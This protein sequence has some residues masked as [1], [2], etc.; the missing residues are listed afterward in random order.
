MH[1]GI[2]TLSVIPGK[3]AGGETYLAGLVRG[4]AAVD[5]ENRY[6]LFV[7]GKNRERFEMQ[8]ANFK[9]VP[10]P[11]SQRWRV[12][13]VLYEHFG[14]PRLTAR[15]GVDVLYCPG[16]AASNGAQCAVVLGAQSMHYCFVPEEVGRLRTSYFKRMVPRS[17]KRADMVIAVSEDIKRTLLSVVRIPESK[18]R[19]VYEGVEMGF[20]RP[21]GEAVEREL[22]RAGLR[23]GFVLFVSTL[24]PY[25]NADKLIRAMAH[26]KRAYGVE[27]EVV[28]AGRDPVALTGQLRALAKELG[29]GDTVR[30]LGGVEHERL[31]FF[32]GGADVFVYP[33]SIET[34]GL[35]I[36]EAMACGTP[37][38][39]SNC[40]SVPEIMGDAGMAVDPEDIAGMAEVIHG[41]L[42]DDHLR[43]DLRK[44]GLARVAEFTWER[45]A[46]ETL[47]V[48][49]AAYRKWMASPR[50]R[51]NSES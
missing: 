17:A 49:A 5:G 28:I 35:P 44:R 13:R 37:V 16:N 11:V 3:T 6:S 4:L 19:V 27:K 47:E 24:K 51:L 31:P 43:E 36:L 30:F 15:M 39:G 21:P 41:V 32:Y 25:K 46:R 12:G 22:A 23:P 33:S 34:F 50:R 18:V 29:I 2:N 1:I 9:C 42:T 40:T 26:L 14:L 48:F 38:V 8:K 10:V 7:G 45:A 20:R